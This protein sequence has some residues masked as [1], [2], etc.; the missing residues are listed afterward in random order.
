[1]ERARSILTYITAVIAIT[2]GEVQ[3]RTYYV[4]LNGSNSNPGSFNQPWRTIA[5]ATGSSSGVM[6]GD[7]I[8]VRA[9]NYPETVTPAI[10]GTAA[11]PILLRNYQNETVSLDPG[12]FRFEN[13]KN[14]WHLSGFVVQHSDDSGLMVNGSHAVGFLTV[15]HCT[16]SHHKEDGVYLGGSN[17]GGIAIYDCNIEW[18]GEVNGQPSGVEGSGIVMYGNQGKLWARRN[19]IANNWAKGIAHGSPGEFAGDS[20]VVDS[21]QIINNYESG[22]DWAANN[23]FIR[24]NYL[25]LNGTRDPESGEWGDKGLALTNVATGNMVA[26]NVIKSSG[27][28][29]LEPRGSDNKI[30]NN[31]LIKDHYYTT[32]PGSPYASTIIFWET[33]GT[34][35]E[36]KNNIIMNLCSQPDHHFAVI[37]G[38]YQR[39]LQQFWS[40]NLYWC[41]NATAPPPANRPFK[42]YNY[43]GGM[44][45]TLSEIQVAYPNQEVG[46]LWEDPEFV[47]YP[48]SNFNLVLQS[49]AI[50]AGIPVGFPYNGNAPDIGRFETAGNTQPTIEPEI[51]DFITDEDSPFSYDL[52]SHEHDQE[53]RPEELVW[54]FSGLDTSLASAS[55]DSFT[56][57]FSVTLH[58]NQNGSDSFTLTLSDGQ[59]GLDS[60][61]VMLIVNPVNDPPAIFPFVMDTTLQEDT[62]F[63]I[64]LTPFETDV[65]DSGAALYWTVS[66]V[67]A[68]LLSI[69]VDPVTDLLTIVP[70]PNAFGSDNVLLTLHDSGGLTDMQDW[71]VVIEPVNDTPWIDPTVPDQHLES[72]DPFTLY[73]GPYGHD[74]EDSSASLIWGI[75]GVDPALFDAQV[76]TSAQILTITPVAGMQGADQARLSLKDLQGDTTGQNIILTLMGF[77][78]THVGPMIDGIPD[79]TLPVSFAPQPIDLNQY[80]KCGTDPFEELTFYTN[81]WDTT[82]SGGDSLEL[83]A[84]VKGS[85]LIIEL[86]EPNWAGSQLISVKVKDSQSLTD[87]DTF[88]VTRGDKYVGPELPQYDNIEIW[89]IENQVQTVH[90]DSFRV[91]VRDFVQPPGFASFQ[92]RCSHDRT[93]CDAA[94]L[95]EFTF[96]LIPNATNLLSLRIKYTDGSYG[97]EKT[98]EVIEDSIAP[99]PPTGL[100]TRSLSELNTLEIDR[101]PHN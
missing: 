65:E 72:Y 62:V 76:D 47:S 17:F 24:Y 46:S 57:L 11:A 78:G 52:S 95:E 38:T 69:S 77:S 10:S 20:S 58:L 84:S 3:A 79:Y 93:W 44:Y 6:A 1:M 80:V 45:V 18:N 75:T 15:D 14:Y 49:P 16:F 92:T 70:L 96:A 34:G 39:Y 9:G 12:R 41:P 43:P 68:L 31:T 23:S 36:F 97:S 63:S 74:I 32:V 5:Y 51:L 85:S 26:F 91:Y 61:E 21:N 28:W 71:V 90:A 89:R 60:Q 100:K 86:P 67:D 27:R 4:A 22:M 87:A 73:L 94:G 2:V 98:L 82:Q 81:V 54:S 42:L 59:G 33:G 53:Q 50:D 13:G 48:D 8:F 19:L 83:V 55:I 7:S 35:N 37:A 30:Y 66:D 40:H 29:E 88:S 99:A 64:N 56:D 101:S 25:S